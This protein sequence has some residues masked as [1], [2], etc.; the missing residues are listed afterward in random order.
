MR[1]QCLKFEKHQPMVNAEV[2]QLGTFEQQKQMKSLRLVIWLVFVSGGGSVLSANAGWHDPA[3]AYRKPISINATNVAGPLTNFPILISHND[4]DLH[5]RALASGNDLVFTSSD[6]TTKLAHEIESYSN[7]LVTAWVKVPYLAANSYTLLYLY[8]GNAATTNQQSASSVWDGNYNTVWHL[9]EAGNG[10][11][12]EFKDSTANARHARGRGGIPAVAAGKFSVGQSFNGTS[13]YIEG[14]SNIGITGNA[15][16][17]L[18]FWAKLSSGS[19]S[20]VA[21]WGNANN[22]ESFIAGAYGNYWTLAGN[23]A[24]NDWTSIAA[25]STGSWQFHTIVHNG[26]TARWYVNGTEI[27]T[28]FKHSY[29]TTD[30]KVLLG[31]A[32][33]AGT[34][35]YLNGVL[36]EIRI[37]NLARSTNWIRTEYANQNSPA[38]F[39]TVGAEEK[40][41]INTT[42]SAGADH[43]V[44]HSSSGVKVRIATLLENDS[45][46]DGDAISLLAFDAQT[47]NGATISSNSGWL[48]YSPAPGFA[49][50]DSFSYVIADSGGLEATGTVTIAT[51]KTASA[52]PNLGGSE[53]L[54]G[55]ERKVR[56]RG[57]PGRTYII[58]SAT[59][60]EASAWET[61]TKLTA[62]SRGELDFTDA[63]STN[64][65]AD[66]YRATIP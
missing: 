2:V 49:D 58:E 66:F 18:S 24:G 61:L 63:T 39:Y 60:L 57:I 20:A 8:Y 1:H 36:D 34:T 59:K 13:D 21:G 9:K 6:G 25:A 45:D 50:T 11:T 40:P 64:T 47:K 3:W 38:T 31:M 22:N 42:P 33:Y 53:I 43:L 41:V 37:S 32:T 30:G 29:A 26:S 12:R 54:P 28:G 23:G 7:G 27:G 62:N 48:I 65:A 55:G 15:V 17:T 46:A 52:T 19:G 16:R 10:T 4:S 44:R 56:L 5:L 35:F 51:E 14:E